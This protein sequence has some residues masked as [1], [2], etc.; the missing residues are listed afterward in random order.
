MGRRADELGD[1]P[2]DRLV[3]E[4]VSGVPA[5]AMRPCSS[6]TT[7]VRHGHGFDLGRG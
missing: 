5:W 6:M 2:V 7:L 4:F 3:V 1:E